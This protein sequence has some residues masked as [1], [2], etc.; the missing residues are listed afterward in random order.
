MVHAS[1]NYT[2]KDR[3]SYIMNIPDGA[4]KLAGIQKDSRE[5]L[6]ML[7]RNL[8]GAL[9]VKEA[10]KILN[11]T[12]RQTSKILTHFTNTGWLARIK[13][14]TYIALPIEATDAKAFVEDNFVIA[15][16]LFAPC[17][18]GGWSALE[19]WHLTEQVFNSTIVV[20]SKI[21]RNLTP[22]VSGSKFLIKV[23]YAKNFF[24]LKQIW[25]NDIKVQISDPS[26][27]I[28]DILNDPGLAGGIRPVSDALVNYFSSEHKNTELLISYIDKL[29]NR[30][31]YKRLGFL[32]EFLALQEDKLSNICKKRISLGNSKLDPSLKA[33][34]LVKRWNLWIPSGWKQDKQ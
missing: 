33:E 27:T 11:I 24:G 9:T 30:T 31:I 22:D 1:C 28:V 13:Q 10:T 17:Y 2:A 15:N 20:T 8:K 7:R 23:T 4:K 26:R 29:N 3:V 14:G 34:H 19:H 5:K 16:K 18:I 25:R 32:I 21:V 6:S 12:P